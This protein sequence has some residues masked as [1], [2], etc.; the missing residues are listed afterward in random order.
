MHVRTA[1]PLL[2]VGLLL[3]AAPAADPAGSSEA[4]TV[5]REC[6]AAEDAHYDPPSG[7]GLAEC[8]DADGTFDPS[9]TYEATHYTNEVTCGTDH[10]LVPGTEAAGV[11]VSGDLAQS[12]TG[13][14]GFLQACSDGDLPI[15]G[16]ATLEGGAGAS[17]GDGTV[18]ID[19]DQSNTPEQL[20]GWAQVDLGDQTVRCG[21]AYAEGGR[22]DAHN[23]TDE[24]GQE[25]CG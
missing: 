3:A 8:T 21:Q 1:L 14:D 16:R 11:V 18:T 9:R 15:N 23:P 5:Q 24:D 17:G 22:G 6:G 4:E 12:G 13:G 7:Q 19:G 2:A 20:Q 25:D 10:Q